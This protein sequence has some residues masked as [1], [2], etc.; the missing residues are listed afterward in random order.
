MSR[1]CQWHKRE[2]VLYYLPKLHQDRFRKKLRQAYHSKTYRGAK[3][4]LTSIRKELELINQSAVNS[5]DEGLEETLTPHKLGLFPELGRSFKTT[6]CIESINKQLGIYTDRVT[7]WKNSN[8]RKRW[9]AAAL[10]EIEPK[11]IK[12]YG[13]RHLPKL[14]QAM[15]VFTQTQDTSKVA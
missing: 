12:V 11:L 5:L 13:Y 4:K 2:N 9:V 14:R 6:N 3:Q 1:R 15:K 7:Y 10:F 8:Q